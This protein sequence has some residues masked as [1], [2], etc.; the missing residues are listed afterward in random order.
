VSAPR[1]AAIPFEHL[2]AELAA[3]P[4]ASEASFCLG[5]TSLD[6][7]IS[8][9]DKEH[10]WRAAERDVLSALPSFPLDE[11]TT[12]RDKL[13][14]HSASS[15]QLSCDPASLSKY[16]RRLAEGYLDTRGRPVE[17]TNSATDSSRP[18]G[19]ESRLR[20]SWMCRALPPDLLRTARGLPDPDADPFPLNPIVQQMLRDRRFAETHL[21][22]RAALDFSLAWA[23]L[24]RTLTTN[25]T[26]YCDFESVGGCF[27]H[28]LYLGT[29]LV[30]VAVVRLLLSQWLFSGPPSTS[31]V[32]DLLKFAYGY[33]ARQLDLIEG[34]RLVTLLSE[35]RRGKWFESH[36]PSLDVQSKE[37]LARRYAQTRA[38]YR[39]LIYAPNLMRDSSDRKTC[40]ANTLQP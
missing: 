36:P 40:I 10:L 30:H 19:P 39:R 21:H 38:L 24:M 31:S 37:R 5:T 35:L 16:L 23:N 32:S 27:E 17:L 15:E 11:A 34:G 14:F 20:W 18:A 8:R 9:N 29:W 6:P 7:L 33:P 22:L 12:V 4:L 28:G 25:E 1:L 13:W 2:E 3:F 26:A